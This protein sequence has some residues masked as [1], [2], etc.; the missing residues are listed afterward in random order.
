LF[1]DPQLQQIVERWPKLSVELR[2]AIVKIVI[3][4]KPL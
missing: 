4:D 3:D 1:S 2:E